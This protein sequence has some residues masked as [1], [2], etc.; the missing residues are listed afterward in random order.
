MPEPDSDRPVNI[1]AEER[2]HPAIRKL[3]RACIAFARQLAEATT[4]SPSSRQH[5]ANGAARRAAHD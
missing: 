3:A 4:S 2:A 1:T 5:D